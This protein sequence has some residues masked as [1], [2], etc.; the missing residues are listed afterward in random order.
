VG[1][2]ERLLYGK[3]SIETFEVNATLIFTLNNNNNNKQLA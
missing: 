3:A 1:Y 2:R